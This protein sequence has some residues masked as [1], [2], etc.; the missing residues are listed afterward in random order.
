MDGSR[1]SEGSQASCSA[2]LTAGN[3]DDADL[4]PV[5]AL[6][7]VV[8]CERRAALHLVERL[9]EENVFTAEGTV[10]HERVHSLTKTEVRGNVRIARGLMIRS[11][12]LGLSGKADVVEF[13]RT[14]ALDKGGES[15]IESFAALLPGV[16]G[17][18]RPYPVEYKRGRLRS[19]RSFEVQLCAQAM[20]L[21]EMLGIGISRGAIFFGETARRLEIEFDPKL[22][23]ET[24]TAALRLHE[25]VDEG[26]TPSVKYE[27]KCKKCSL[28]SLCMPQITGR[29]GK[30]RT[31]LSRM[32]ADVTEASS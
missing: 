26:L 21:E 31:Y 25:L 29:R 10:G 28:L 16:S 23:Q 2:S 13:H 27:N 22:R 6:Q 24:K 15:P 18:W 1:P 9:W 20:C 17:F 14:E 19:N 30:V 4:L 11:L 8:F 32:V 5:A 3:F 7:D 12:E